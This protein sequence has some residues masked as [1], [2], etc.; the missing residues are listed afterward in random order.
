MDQCGNAN[1]KEVVV[2]SSAQVAKTTMAEN[3][4]GYMVNRR[5][6]P[7]M[8]VHNRADDSEKFS[9]ERI[10]SLIESTPVLRDRFFKSTARA[11]GN[12]IMY[13][14]FRGGSL[15]MAQALSPDSLRGRP[16]GLGIGDE[17][18]SYKDTP[19]GDPIE[20]FEARMIRFP[21]AQ[22]FYFS[23]PDVEG[24]KISKKFERT[25]KRYFHAPCPHCQEYAV[26]AYEEIE[27]VP[28]C[29]LEWEDGAPIRLAN[30]KTIKTAKAAWFT[31]PH[32]AGKINDAQRAEANIAGEWR[33]SA[34][35]EGR[36][37]FW[38]WEANFP[39][40]QALSFANRW[41]S[42]LG[43]SKAM[44]GV[45]NQVFGL[46][47]KEH[48]EVTDWQRLYQRA[49]SYTLA[50]VPGPVRVLFGGIDV[51]VNRLEGYVWGYGENLEQWLIDQIVIDGD[52]NNPATWLQLS[53]FVNAVQYPGENG[54]VFPVRQWAIDSGY[55]A[56]KVYEWAAGFSTEMVRVVKGEQNGKTFGRRGGD[57]EIQT[58]HLKRKIGH[59]LWMANKDMLIGQLYSWLANETPTR[60]KLEAGEGYPTGYVHIP[61]MP[62][63]FFRQLTAD[64]KMKG[65]FQDKVNFHRNEALDIKCYCDLLAWLFR[66]QYRHS[67]DLPLPV[68]TVQQALPQAQLA[69]KPQQQRAPSMSGGGGGYLGSR[70]G[71][72]SR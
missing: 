12:T 48:G 11:S 7:I 49:E 55:L 57:I 65:V 9:K 10:S 1:V 8:V 40:S 52:P 42:A 33:A 58:G 45:K 38:L 67:N 25:D 18:S 4:I 5:P 2:M 32:C 69:A 37:G 24:D 36:A 53:N 41:L 34:A 66:F 28:S 50:T 14:R 46:P 3:I 56:P 30:G 19:Q 26:F 59:P 43:E 16:I 31:C 62:E 70:K 72:L 47:W 54:Q 22:R 60:E 13:K 63:E 21:N 51:Q 6:V 68:V 20:L 71:W 15:T 64:V 29:L 17:V 23:T 27:G 35:F 61:Q 39:G 44:Q